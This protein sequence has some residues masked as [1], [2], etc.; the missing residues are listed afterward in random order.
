MMNASEKKALESLSCEVRTDG[1]TRQIYATDASL[2]QVVPEAVAFP[3]SAREAAEAIQAA[4]A[5]NLAVTP[6]GAG[7]GLAGAAVGGGL[8]LELARHNRQILEF[9]KDARTIR[10]GAGVVLDQLNAYLQPHG[11]CFGPDVA[12]S[13]R[14]TIGGMIANNS[15]GARAP[16]YGVTID[17]VRSLEVALADGRVVEV[18]AEKDGFREH[19][20]AID[21]LIAPFSDEIRARFHERIVKRWPGYAVDRYLRHPRDMSKLLGGSEGTLAAIFSA[22]L[23]LVPIPKKKGLGLL[24]FASVEEAMQAT[25]RLLELQ[26]A[27]IEH[28]DDVLFDQTRGQLQFKAARELLELDAKPCK[29]ILLVEFYEDDQDKLHALTGMNLG[30]RSYICKNAGEM[31][32]VWNMRKAGLSL[33]SGCAGAA[34]PATG[35]EDVAVPTGKL[36][37]FVAGVRELLGPLGLEASYYGHAAAGLLHIRPVVDLH[38][39]EDIA[40]F[41]LVAEGISKL[42]RQF[43]GSIAAEHGVGIARAE[44]LEEQ[45]GAGLIGLMRRI[46]ALFDPKNVM[47]PG[48]IFPDGAR[49]DRDLRQGP[50]VRI[51]VPFVPVLA[52]AAKDKSFAGNLEQCNG[53]GGCRKDTPTMCPTFIAMGEEIMSTRGRANAI[54]AVLEHRLD[55]HAHPLDSAALEEALCYCL[56]CKA[57]AAECPSNVNMPLLKAELVHARQEKNGLSLAERLFSRV[58]QLGR[59]GTMLPS[60]ANASLQWRWLRKLMEATIGIDARRPLPPYADEPFD[61][62]FTKRPIP[63]AGKRGRVILW[64][65]CFCNYHEPNIGQAAVRVLEAAGCDVVVPLGHGCCGRPAF[66]MGRIDLAASFGR[67]NLKRLRASGDAIVFL[68]ASCFSMFVEDYRELR[69]DGAEDVAQRCFLFEQFVENLF[70]KEPD[71]LKFRDAPCVTAIHA[72]CH[73]KSLTDT[74]VMPRLARRIPGNDVTLLDTGCCGMA[75]A[76]GAQKGKY[77]VSVKVAEPL[78]TLLNA[79]PENARVVASGTS[80]RHQVGHLTPRKPLHMAELLALALAD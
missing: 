9:N 4:V 11:L 10:V 16:I 33:L 77:D 45:I 31:A 72:H 8:V 46:K 65:D 12:T 7:T 52:F 47:N 29:A 80:C 14:A 62:W 78:I 39:A 49:I 57:C 68:E 28:I 73:A 25:V 38:K 2:Y 21:A 58:D 70:A 17:H 51:D 27:G 69:L 3:K 23:N 74:A 75:G 26:P 59:L 66:S 35:V 30:L 6:R 56:S 41:R 13:S 44:F 19:L 1:L 67:E 53:C 43:N 15:S 76:Y 63:V 71:V 79:L 32:H 55:T 48:K 5:A 20:D 22:E 54:R 60:L 36:P 50:E 37:D 42:T 40:K 24:F 61:R 64:N 18:G 34:K